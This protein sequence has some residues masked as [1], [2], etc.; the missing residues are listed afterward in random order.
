[1]ASEGGA[2]AFDAIGAARPA[3]YFAVLSA[4]GKPTAWYH[5]SVHGFRDAPSLRCIQSEDLR[6]VPQVVV[7]WVPNSDCKIPADAVEKT[8][9]EWLRW[10]NG[11]EPG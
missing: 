10:T 5:E 2:Q 8:D 6:E 11:R 1:M 4:E 9:A 3:R 7:D